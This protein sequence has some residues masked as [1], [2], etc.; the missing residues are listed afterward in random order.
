MAVAGHD[1]P[2]DHFLLRPLFVRQRGTHIFSMYAPFLVI[3]IAYVYGEKINRTR[4]VFVDC[5]GAVCSD[6][7]NRRGRW[8]RAGFLASG[9]YFPGRAAV[10]KGSDNIRINAARPC[11]GSSL[12]PP[13][14]FRTDIEI[15]V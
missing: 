8:R 13:G 6:Y 9:P 12:D 1:G 11:F 7:V 4:M 2:R 14:W 3:L 15:T 10:L 5:S